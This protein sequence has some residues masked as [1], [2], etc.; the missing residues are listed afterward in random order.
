M[1]T[2]VATQDSTIAAE[3]MLTK[4]ALR[5]SNKIEQYD[6]RENLKI[7]GLKVEEHEEWREVVARM[8]TKDLGIHLNKKTEISQ[9]PMKFQLGFRKLQLMEF[10]SPLQL[11]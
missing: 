7:H 8:I 6:R 10:H 2:K 3:E 5:W 1:L 11:L 4:D 9:L